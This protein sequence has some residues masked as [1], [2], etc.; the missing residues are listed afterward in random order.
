MSNLENFNISQRSDS[1][2]AQLVSMADSS[3]LLSSGS[4]LS[5]PNMSIPEDKKLPAQALALQLPPPLLRPIRKAYPS[6]GELRSELSIT[7]EMLSSPSPAR[8]VNAFQLLNSHVFQ[9]ILR[10][11]DYKSWPGIPECV[12]HG[13]SCQLL[14]WWA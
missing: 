14:F 1:W 8:R 9:K 4:M 6:R 2:E 3:G 12:E 5:C 13:K 7:P 11:L 10:C